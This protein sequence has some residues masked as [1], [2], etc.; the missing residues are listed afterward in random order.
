[1]LFKAS[2]FRGFILF[3]LS[4]SVLASDSKTITEIKQI[5]KAV[6][7]SFLDGYGINLRYLLKGVEHHQILKVELSYKEIEDAEAAVRIFEKIPDLN[8][9]LTGDKKILSIVGRRRQALRALDLARKT[10]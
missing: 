5:E 8:I 6:C 7:K 1:M 3:S 4:T 10:L 2:I 9:I